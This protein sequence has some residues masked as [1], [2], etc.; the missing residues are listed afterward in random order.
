[1]KIAID[2]MKQLLVIMR[3]ANYVMH[4]FPFKMVLSHS[5]FIATLLRRYILKSQE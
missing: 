4:F 5:L 3:E 2:W 1:M